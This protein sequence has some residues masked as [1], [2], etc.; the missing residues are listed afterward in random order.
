[1]NMIVEKQAAHT[2]SKRKVTEANE[3]VHCLRMKASSATPTTAMKSLVLSTA[4]PRAAA[5]CLLDVVL[6]GELLVLVDV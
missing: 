5:L 4:V 6:A 3:I 2:K 1:M